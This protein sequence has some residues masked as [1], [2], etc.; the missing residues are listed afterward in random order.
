MGVTFYLSH[1]DIV[2]INRK[3]SCGLDYDVGNDIEGA[4]EYNEFIRKRIYNLVSIKM[5]DV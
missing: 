1:L 4:M 2:R 5:S 3:Y